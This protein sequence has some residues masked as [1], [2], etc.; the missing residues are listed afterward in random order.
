MSEFRRSYKAPHPASKLSFFIRGFEWLD[1][2]SVPPTFTHIPVDAGADR[3]TTFAIEQ[4]NA[5]YEAIK[6][7]IRAKVIE[8]LG[9]AGIT[10]AANLS[11]YI[12]R[13]VDERLLFLAISNQMLDQASEGGLPA[14]VSLQT[15]VIYACVANFRGADQ[16]KSDNWC[17]NQTSIDLN[18]GIPRKSENQGLTAHH[19][20]R[21]DARFIKECLSASKELRCGK[22]LFLEAFKAMIWRDRLMVQALDH[23]WQ[24]AKQHVLLH[25]HKGYDLADAIHDYRGIPQ[26]VDWWLERNSARIRYA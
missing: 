22:A 18:A 16:R 23:L 1:A 5:H 11:G 14:Y 9:L 20:R 3:D 13:V 6:T 12:D 2:R 25:S 10:E 8:E 26:C 21:A 24:Q 17:H 4:N 15:R 19:I 7:T